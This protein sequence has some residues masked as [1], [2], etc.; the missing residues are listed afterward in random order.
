MSQKTS[1]YASVV[2]VLGPGNM[3]PL[4]IEDQH[5]TPYWKLP[6]GRNEAGEDPLD[7]AV[8]ELWEETGLELK[9][10]DLVQLLVFNRTI[11]DRTHEFYL[12]GAKTDSFDG[13]REYG[14]E[15]ERVGLFSEHNLKTMLELLPFHREVLAKIGF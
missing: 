1:D 6:G 2:L 8:R 14:T 9:K 5:A 15:G 11:H 7:T 10:S 13:L 4:V 12:F 3:V